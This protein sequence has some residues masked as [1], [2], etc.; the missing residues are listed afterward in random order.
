MIN[1]QTD[2][3]EGQLL[4]FDKPLYWTSFDLVKKVKNIIRNT[5]GY[6]KIKVGH[7]GTLDPLAS[8]LMII[9]TGKYT[10]RIGELQDRNKEYIAT[11]HLGETTPSFD[12]E[13]EVDARFETGHIKRELIGQALEHF[14]GE[15]QQVP[16]VF[17]AKNINGRRAYDY[18]RKGIDVKMEA[19]RVFFHELELL[20]FDLPL[21]KIRI[22]CSKGTYIRSFARDFGSYLGSGAYLSELKRTAIGEYKLEDAVQIIE[23]EQ[24]MNSVRNS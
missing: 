11:L 15:Y 23:F 7:A 2:F 4:L 1:K 9:C 16:P 6:K 3:L 24:H 22:L 17:S 5:Y 19:R 12:L 14:L 21:V 10:R 8:G 13:T 18:A 20:D